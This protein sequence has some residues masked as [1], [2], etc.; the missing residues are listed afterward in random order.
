MP[1]RL[2]RCASGN[3]VDARGLD[4]HR[5]VEVDRERPQA[6][7]GD[8]LVDQEDHLLRAAHREGRDQQHA[9]ARERARQH[10]LELLQQRHRGV[11]AG[12][13][14]CSPPPCSRPRGAGSGSFA[15]TASKRPTSPLNSTRIAL[16]PA[17]RAGPPTP[18]RAGGPRRGSVNATLGREQA[19]VC[20]SGDR[21]EQLEARRHVRRV[22][23]RQR[24]LVLA[25]GPCG[26]GSPRPLAAGARRPS[27]AS[28]P[29]RAWPGV[30]KIAPAE[31]LLD[32]P[33][34]AADVVEVGVGQD[35]ARR[36]PPGRTA[37]SA[38]LR[39][40]S[41]FSPWNIPQSTSSRVPPASTQVLRAGHGARGAEEAEPRH[42]RPRGDAGEHLAQHRLQDAAVAVVVDLHRRVEPRR[43]RE[44]AARAVA[45]RATSTVTSWRGR[46]SPARPR[47]RRAARGR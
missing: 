4:G 5:A 36:P 47:D 44:R 40:R 32:E 45:R 24:R 30:Q 27:A 25:S 43:G 10:A 39:R 37:G 19:G 42:V 21:L 35:Q 6:A 1:F 29:A 26:S 13:R 9:A 2:T 12:C 16:R 14:R 3:G 22:E 18:R 8:E 20:P 31:A 23:Q 28:R 15:S 46:S 38:Q 41:A 17:A 7:L 34:H 11:R 33:R